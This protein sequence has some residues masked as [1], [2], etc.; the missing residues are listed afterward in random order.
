M[1]TTLVLTLIGPD[2]PGLVE[3]LSRT[4][5][6]HEGNWLE[7][8]MARMAGKFTGILRVHVP[9]PQVDALTVALKAL[10]AGGLRVSV[11]TGDDQPAA[12]APAPDARTMH[13]E[14]LGQDRPGIVR[15]I[16]AALASRGVNVEELATQCLSA[17]MTGETL[18]KCTARLEIPASVTTAEL[19]DALEKIADELMVDLTLGENA[20]A[21][22]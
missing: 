3:A 5:A 14:L 16:A 10:A 18:F 4:I 19:H 1:P 20:T 21:Q 7:S 9:A 15:Q 12:V 2:R 6:A 13:L 17:P 11:D 22:S 8:R